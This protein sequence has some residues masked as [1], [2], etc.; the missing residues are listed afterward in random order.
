[1]LVKL[2]PGNF[3]FNKHVGEIDKGLILPT[4]YAQLSC[5]QIPKDVAFWGSVCIKAARKMLVKL[6]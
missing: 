1:M 4:S 3:L 6:T 5:T 2:T